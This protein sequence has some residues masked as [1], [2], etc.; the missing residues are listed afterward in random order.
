M[1]HLANDDFR[2]QVCA[3]LTANN[4]DPDRIP[5][6][7]RISTTSDTITY[8]R[9]VLGPDGHAQ[10]DPKDPNQVLTETV[11]APLLK[12]PP[13]EVAEWLRPKCPTCGR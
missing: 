11:T 9:T 3:W 1:R 13:P 10:R 12:G 8:P 6:N 4:I 7:C 2:Q 5:M